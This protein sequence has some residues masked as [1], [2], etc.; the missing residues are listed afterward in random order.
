MRYL[1]FLAK[2]EFY[3][4]ADFYTKRKCL[5]ENWL[6]FSCFNFDSE[7]KVI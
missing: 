2:I 6:K 7:N 5:E 4:V 3:R 1:N